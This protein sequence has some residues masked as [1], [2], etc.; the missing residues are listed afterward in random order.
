MPVEG[1]AGNGLISE[2]A[3]APHC[4]VV[5][6]CHYHKHRLTHQAHT[7]SLAFAYTRAHTSN[8]Y[9]IHPSTYTSCLT[10]LLLFPPLS[11]PVSLTRHC[12]TQWNWPVIISNCSGVLNLFHPVPYSGT[13]AETRF[14]SRASVAVL[15]QT[16]KRVLN[17][18][19]I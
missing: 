2:L 9:S 18:V 8:T 6:T 11:F 13:N 14:L 16:S 3:Q 7:R 4:Y 1:S 5:T 12:G 10:C 19:V 15:L 17:A